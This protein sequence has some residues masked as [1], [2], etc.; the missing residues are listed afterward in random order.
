MQFVF[1]KERKY[2]PYAHRRFNEDFR[3]ENSIKK[4]E[5]LQSSFFTWLREMENQNR[6]FSP[7][8]LSTNNAFDFVKGDISLITKPI[9]SDNIRY[10]N[11]ARV[12]NELNRQISKTDKAL[13]NESRFL[14]LFY[15]ATESLINFKS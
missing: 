6:R 4:L 3:K 9:W 13:G 15:R 11:W 7:F 2:Q 8:N 12:D 1:E 10:K 5:S 14:E